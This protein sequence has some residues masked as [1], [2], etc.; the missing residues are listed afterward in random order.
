M[1]SLNLY[2]RAE[3]VLAMLAPSLALTPSALLAHETWP[4]EMECDSDAE[5]SHHA[6]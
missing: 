3:L 6:I 4:A 2:A 5:V 1:G